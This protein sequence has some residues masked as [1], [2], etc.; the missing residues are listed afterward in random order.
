MDTNYQELAKNLMDHMKTVASTD[1]VVGEQFSLGEFTC[2]P[3]IKLNMGIGSGGG[4]GDAPKSGK[5]SG[6]GAG[7]GVQVEPIAFLVAHGADIKLMNIRKGR[8][9]ESFFEAIPEVMEKFKS[10]KEEEE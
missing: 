1:T 8:G 9:I 7:A 4:V 5:G 6:G 10:H 3:V 2:V